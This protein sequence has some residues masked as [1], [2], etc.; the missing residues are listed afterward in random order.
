VRY[1]AL[2]RGVSPMNC[3]MADLR[4][5]LEAAGFE[6]V[7]TVL[8]SGNAVFDA[9]KQSTA[10]LE[11]KCEAAFPAFLGRGFVTIVRPI[12]YLERLLGS[13]PYSGVALP[14]HFSREVTFLR[15]QPATKFASRW[16]GDGVF[17]R[18]RG[19]EAFS[20][21][22][23]NEDGVLALRLFERTFGKEQTTRTWRTVE[24]VA[25]SD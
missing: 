20:A 8:S 2:L 23:A 14:A 1:A 24:R 10:G 22:E 12:D 7:V 16:L 6:N 18:V 5:A 9:R 17:V 21:Y 19:T 3:R 15:R 13:R 25:A 4:R 11:K